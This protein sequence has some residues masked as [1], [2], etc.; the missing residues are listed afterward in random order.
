M[1]QALVVFGQTVID[2]PNADRLYRLDERKFVRNLHDTESSHITLLP[3][4]NEHI[5]NRP[6]LRNGIDVW[7]L[8]K[9]SEVH[10]SQRFMQ[11]QHNQQY[12]SVIIITMSKPHPCTFSFFT[13][14]QNTRI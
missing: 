4:L 13:P 2:S 1:K 6:Y 10:P 12:S 8:K 7:V 11:P 5:Y 3:C 9:R 14:V